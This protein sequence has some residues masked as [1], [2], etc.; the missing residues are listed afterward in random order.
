MAYAGSSRSV[1]IPRPSGRGSQQIIIG[2]L[3]RRTM[4]RCTIGTGTHQCAA[5]RKPL[6]AIGALLQK[7]PLAARRFATQLDKQKKLEIERDRHLLNLPYLRLVNS[8]PKPLKA[9]PMQ[10]PDRA[11][12]PSGDCANHTDRCYQGEKHQA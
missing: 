1:S 3:V 5:Q 8:P 7:N 12:I 9:I 6:R 2:R 11:F 4:H 10:P